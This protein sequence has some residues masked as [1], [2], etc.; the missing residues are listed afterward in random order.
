[1]S[2]SIKEVLSEAGYD[3]N[4]VKDAQW[5]LSQ[6]DE[7]GELCDEAEHTID[8]YEEAELLEEEE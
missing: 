2:V 7:F 6:M 5:V 3:I 4:N 8:K 1:M